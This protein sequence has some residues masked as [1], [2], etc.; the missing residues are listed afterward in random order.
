MAELDEKNL[1]FVCIR[2]AGYDCRVLIASTYFLGQSQNAGG[3]GMGCAVL[4]DIKVVVST[5]EACFRP[6]PWNLSHFS[7]VFWFLHDFL[8]FHFFLFFFFNQFRSIIFFLTIFPRVD[9]FKLKYAKLLPPVYFIKFFK[10]RETWI[11]KKKKKRKQREEIKKF[12]HQNFQE[13]QKSSLVIIL[14]HLSPKVAQIRILF[15][16]VRRL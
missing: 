7:L 2:M 16:T 8:G 9:F 12:C 13:V 11:Q 3:V 6:S 1:K 5:I 10:S 4:R 15:K 14:F